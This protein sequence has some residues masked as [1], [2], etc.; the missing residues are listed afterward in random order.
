MQDK[1]VTTVN[2]KDAWPDYPYKT[3]AV[4][5]PLAQEGK[6]QRR[7]VTQGNKSKGDKSRWEYNLRTIKEYASGKWNPSKRYNNETVDDL[8]GHSGTER[9]A[10]E[11]GEH[12][13]NS[14]VSVRLSIELQKLRRQ[15]EE[16]EHLLRQ[17]QRF[18]EE[19]PIGTALK[20]KH[21]FQNRYTGDPFSKAYDYVALRANNGFWYLTCNGSKTMTWEQLVEFIG[22]EPVA[23]MVVGEVL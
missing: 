18:P 14:R 12:L 17:A 20:F 6:I 4:L 9:A 8:E 7:P 19:F 21:V 16:V 10:D 2:V 3:T 5:A 11:L 1:W 23:R 15:Q 13:R 22:D